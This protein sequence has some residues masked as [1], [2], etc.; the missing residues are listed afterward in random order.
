MNSEIISNK[1]RD[2]FIQSKRDLPW[3]IEKSPYKVW[4]SEVMLQQTQVAVVLDY[5]KKWM[6]F[7]PTVQALANAPIDQVIKCWEGLGYYSRAHN[8]HKGAQHI[9]ESHN[10]QF[11]TSYEELTQIPGVGPY[12]ARAIQAFAFGQHACPV[13][14]NIKR[15]I[16]RIH[17]IKDPIDKAST[18][19]LIQQYGDQ[20]LQGKSPEVVAEGLIEFGALI[21]KKNPQC[22]KCPLSSDCQAFKAGLTEVLPN[23]KKR[24]P[25]VQLTRQLLF[26]MTPKQILL[27]KVP[28]GKI[29]AGLY[30]PPFISHSQN[31]FTSS[32]DSEIYKKLQSLDLQKDVLKKRQHGF[33]KYK[34]SLHPEAYLIKEAFESD[35]F[36]WINLNQVEKLSFPAGVRQSVEEALKTHQTAIKSS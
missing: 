4:V 24:K 2:W 17:A 34:V 8:L 16:S 20:L 23:S 27:Q 32:K 26:I 18:L 7:F 11:P 6:R 33:T 31:E 21:C 3:R 25:S 12:T 14:G 19:K 28:Q 5:F 30:M 36:E 9:L 35:G 13:D 15:V 10:G 29:M 1:I 22:Q